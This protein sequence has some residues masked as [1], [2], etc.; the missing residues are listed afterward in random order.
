MDILALLQAHSYLF[1]FLGML[2]GGESVLIPAVYLA[3]S[4][5]LAYAPLFFFAALATIV[6]DS[7]WYV[8]GRRLSFERLKRSRFTAKHAVA[9]TRVETL[10]AKHG[11]KLLFFSKFVYGT[12]IALQLLS[13]MKRVSFVRYVLVNTAG[14]LG[15]LVVTLLLALLI[16]ASAGALGQTIRHIE[17]ASFFILFIVLVL[18]HLWLHRTIKHRWFQ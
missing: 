5:K 17:I 13:G 10:M 1:L 4:G 11:L 15:Y 3:I 2:V 12:R 16:D 18:A 7:V 6:S 14:V 9:V 8:V